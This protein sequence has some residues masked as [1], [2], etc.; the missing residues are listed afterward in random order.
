[1]SEAP[2]SI[3]PFLNGF[4]LQLLLSNLPT[5]LVFAILPYI[6]DELGLGVTILGTLFLLVRV[7]AILGAQ[8]GPRLL[9][10]FSAKSI[11]VVSELLN[12]GLSGLL[13]WAIFSKVDLLLFLVV[14]F[15]GVNSGLLH[16]ARLHWLKNLHPGVE[17]QRVLLVLNS[18]GQ[19]FYGIAGVFIL[20]GMVGS[21]A[22]KVA[23]LMDALSSL[24]GAYVFSRI[25]IAQSE[26]IRSRMRESIRLMFYGNNKWLIFNDL[27]LCVAFAGT[28]MLLVKAGQNL[29]PQ[30]GGYATAL[31]IYASGFLVSGWYSQAR[32]GASDHPLYKLIWSVALPVVL[33][34][35]LIFVIDSFEA[36]FLSSSLWKIVL[37]VGFFSLFF[38]YPLFLLR[39][40]GVWFRTLEKQSIAGVFAMR[41]SLIGL[42]TAVGEPFYAAIGYRADSVIR[43]GFLGAA[44]V[45][46]QMVAPRF[47]HLEAK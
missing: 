26:P 14:F 38:T 40:D 31:I 34:G 28:N 9:R 45:M 39:L 7:G 1:M 42:V 18:L 41:V 23:I 36:A 10:R 4:S 25:G 47:K 15:K 3:R 33:M 11:A 2:T 12:G 8:V 46:I 24:I 13:A 17:G 35:P 16:N 29:F 20:F 6:A 5:V 19:S 37:G 44:V 30:M 27:L 43:F 32:A 22:I 21:L